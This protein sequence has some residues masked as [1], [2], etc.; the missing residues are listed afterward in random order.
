VAR[1]D[2]RLASLEPYALPAAWLI[3][4]L[5]ALPFEMHVPYVKFR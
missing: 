1:L 4:V 2:E 3:L 5:A